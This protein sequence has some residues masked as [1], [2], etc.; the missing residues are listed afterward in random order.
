MKAIYYPNSNILD[1]PVGGNPSQVWRS[2]CEG[3]DILNQGL[4]RRIGDGTTT[5]IWNS[6]WLPRDFSLRPLCPIAE[7]PPQMVSELFCPVTR[8]WDLEVLNKHFLPMDVEIIRH[9]PISFSVQAD[10]WDWH[11]EKTGNFS[12]R[13]A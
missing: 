9:I 7:D 3:R 6:N 11:Y 2:L 12:V 1:A 13:S 10:F 5:H 8:T 4:V